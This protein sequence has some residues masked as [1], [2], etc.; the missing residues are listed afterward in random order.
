MKTTNLSI[1]SHYCKL[2]IVYKNEVISIKLWLKFQNYIEFFKRANETFFY[3]LV[4]FINGQ[5]LL[6]IFFY[7]SCADSQTCIPV[8]DIN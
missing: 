7:H 3:V 2:K 1:N 8:K 4:I 6:S 5:V